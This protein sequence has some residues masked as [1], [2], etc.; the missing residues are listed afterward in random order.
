MYDMILPRWS[1]LNVARNLQGFLNLAQGLEVSLLR[2]G[3]VAVYPS[4]C[5]STSEIQRCLPGVMLP[6]R[7]IPTV[8]A[9]WSFIHVVWRTVG[10][11][12]YL[13]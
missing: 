6:S 3:Q 5:F 7:I 4:K 12:G 11:G 9:L 10:L 1:F 13:G 8:R 2:A